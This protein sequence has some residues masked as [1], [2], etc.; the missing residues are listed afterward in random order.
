MET[1]EMK[2]EIL[3]NVQKSL[4]HPSKLIFTTLNGLFPSLTRLKSFA[5]RLPKQEMQF[6]GTTLL[7]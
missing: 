7:I 5:L 6:I 2:Y 3:R 1:D 4:K